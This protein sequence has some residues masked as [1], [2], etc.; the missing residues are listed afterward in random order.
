M[1]FRDLWTGIINFEEPKLAERFAYDALSIWHK[2]NA[3]RMQSSLIGQ[4]C[5]DPL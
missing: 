2:R 3:M 4:E 5:I 1:D